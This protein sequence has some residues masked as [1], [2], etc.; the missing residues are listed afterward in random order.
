MPATDVSALDGLMKRFYGKDFTDQQ[1]LVPDYLDVIEEG[2]EEPGGEDASIR[3]GAGIAVRQSGG[4]QREKEQFRENESGTKK[5]FQLQVR[6]NIWPVEMTNLAVAAS[7]GTNKAFMSGLD[8]EMKEALTMAKKDKNRQIF[9]SALGQLCL[10]NGAVVNSATVVI[11]TPDGQY[12]FPGMRID[13]WTAVAG[14]QEAANVKILTISDDRLTI[15]LSQVVTVSNNAIICR[16]NIL[17]GVTGVDDAKEVMGFEGMS[18]DNTLFTNFQGLSRAT[19]PVLNGSIVDASNAAVTGD[20]LQRSID[21][22]ETRSGKTV[23]RIV[24]HRVQRR[25]Y[26]SLVTPQK[27]FMSDK[28]DA[29]FKVLE[30][31]NIPWVVSH[32]CQRTSI[33][34]YVSSQVRK[35]EL[36]K[37]ALDDTGGTTI[38]KIPRTDTFESYYKSYDCVG[39][40]QPAAVGRIENLA[41][42][43]E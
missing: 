37:L 18:D 25:Q 24:S 32:E 11:D 23:D 27:R 39:T 28:L 6:I 14:V 35:W 5:Q 13:I 10:V 33:Y 34:P 16:S 22:T 26:L 15:T 36:Q 7:K 31:N 17:T 41:T 4:A 8:R 29:G 40:Y 2:T 1:Q 9:G 12:L 38:H 3:F 30:F 21:R 43:S 20:M 42:L 19:Y